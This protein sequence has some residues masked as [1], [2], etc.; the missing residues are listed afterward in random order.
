MVDELKNRLLIL[1]QS[2]QCQHSQM[3]HFR[4]INTL[5]DGSIFLMGYNLPFIQGNPVGL[6]GIGKTQVRVE[7]A[8][9]TRWKQLDYAIFWM[10]ILNIA[11]FEPENVKIHTAS[12]C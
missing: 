7:F 12:I 10:L 4:R 8:H 5:L 1:T 6:R 2:R 3:S 9:P 11:A